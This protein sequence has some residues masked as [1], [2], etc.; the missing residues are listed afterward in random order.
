[1]LIEDI[2][3]FEDKSPVTSLKIYKNNKKGMRKLIV[4][5]SSNIASIPLHRCN[6]MK[7]CRSCIGLQDP[8]CAWTT[9]GGCVASDRGNEGIQTGHH[10]IC[11]S[12]GIYTIYRLHDHFISSLFLIL[13]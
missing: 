11:N 8:Y 1:M 5:S 13:F 6:E 7:S 4:L 10:D 12:E 2:Q 3:V 9:S